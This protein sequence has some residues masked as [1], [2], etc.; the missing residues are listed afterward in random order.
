[1]ALAD[2]G[3]TVDAIC[4][5]GHPLHRMSVTRQ[6]Y[7]YRGLTPLVSIVAAIASAKPDLVIP[8][9]DLA[10]R[11]LHKLYHRERD[12]ETPGTET[13]TLLERSLGAP[14]SFPVVNERTAFIELAQAEGVRVPKTALVTNTSDL[15]KWIARAGFPVVLKSNGTSGGEGVR[16][17]N[18]AADAE[19][20]LRRLQAPPSLARGAKRALIDRDRTLIWPSL[21]RSRSVVNTQEFVTGREATSLV[22]CWNGTILACLHFEVLAKL[23]S[24]GPAT[25][26]RLLENAE[27]SAV[28]KKMARRLKLSG[29]HGFDF[30]L[31]AQTGSP[32]LIEMNPRTTQVGHLTLGP[33]RDLPAALYAA[34]TGQYVQPSPKLTKNDTIA[35]FPAEWT[36]NPASAY[37]RSGYHDVPWEEPGLVSAC[38]LERRKQ[39][40][41]YSRRRLVRAVS[42]ARLPRL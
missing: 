6:T 20:A 25:V 15:E 39:L 23:D 26:L 41:C 5:S 11:H 19:R 22:A 37:L 8:G 16:I 7:P 13:C 12:R 32:Y 3:F 34:I 29:L 10:T 14:E 33:G 2:A 9:D 31:T 27:M 21:L 4:P 1:M 30:M 35:L 24:S 28:T 38:L 40:A 42:V 36:R 18:T 17:V